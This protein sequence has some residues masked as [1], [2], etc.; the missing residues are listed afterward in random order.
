[1]AL[2]LIKAAY[3]DARR[4]RAAEYNPNANPSRLAVR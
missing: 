4:V 3:R 1:M 2:L